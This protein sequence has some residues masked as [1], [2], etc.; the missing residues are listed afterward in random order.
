[1]SGAMVERMRAATGAGW[2]AWSRQSALPVVLV[3]LVLAF[4][5]QGTRGLWEPDEGRYTDVA[6]EMLAHGDFLQ[7]ALNHET[8][9]FTKPPLTYWMLASSVALFGRNEWAVRLPNA[10]AYLAT[11]L[12]VLAAARR[13]VP[14]APSWAA[15]IYATSLLPFAAANV[16]TTDT[17]LAFWETLAVTA[18]VAAWWGAEARRH[19]YLW[20]MWAAFGLAF[21]TKGPPGLLPLLPIVVF[22]LLAKRRD[23]RLRW[24]FPPLG[25]VLFLLLAGWW[26]VVVMVHRPELLGYFLGDEVIGRVA[27]AEFHR[28]AAWYGAFEVYL[29]VLLVGSLPWTWPMLAAVA[30]GLRSWWRRRETA[31]PETLFLLLWLLLPLAV[32]F[33]ARSRLPFYLIPLFVPLALLA[34]RRLVRPQARPR[35]WLVV[36][37][38]WI[39]F[40]VGIKATAGY[41]PDHHKDSRLLASALVRGAPAEYD[42]VLF[43]DTWPRYGLSLYLGREVEMVML[44]WKEPQPGELV[45]PATLAS[46]LQEHERR[47]VVAEA[48]ELPQVTAKLE[49]FDLEPEPYGRWHELVFFTLRASG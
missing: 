42:E 24:L 46:E 44:A 29:P 48:K 36:A 5:F 47:I 2:V 10:L 16:V 30:G 3:A 26:F 7:P 37:A 39:V 38:V 1:M 4:A 20:G 34:A 23:R 6:L 32:F 18:F 14:A 22:V 19:R 17:L 40:L 35:R 41:W 21:F 8:P 49:E 27:T 28:N 25:V 31:A 11:V 13:L 9:H 33:V 43:V 12:L 45:P 15:L